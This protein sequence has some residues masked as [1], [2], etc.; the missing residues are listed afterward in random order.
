MTTEQFQEKQSQMSNEELISLAREE[1]AKL[2]KTGGQSL[3]MCV[4]PSIKDTDMLLCEVIKRLEDL[5]NT[6]KNQQTFTVECNVCKQRYNNWTG[7]TPCC[8]SIAYLVEDGVA[9]KKASL[10][11]N[12]GKAVI[13]FEE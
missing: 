11:S 10:F 5:T 13:D 4:P 6:S 7:S 12:M 3:R 2:C 8:G 9:S 1:V